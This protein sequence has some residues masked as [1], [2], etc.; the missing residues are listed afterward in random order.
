MEALKSH[1]PRSGVIV[2]LPRGS[3]IELNKLVVSSRLAR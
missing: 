2:Y 1:D 3:L